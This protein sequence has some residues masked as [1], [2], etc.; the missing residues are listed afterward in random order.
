[1]VKYFALI[2]VLFVGRSGSIHSQE[3]N[4]DEPIL[5]GIA[6]PE[7]SEPSTQPILTREMLQNMSKKPPKFIPGLDHPPS[8]NPLVPF[9]PQPRPVVT[10]TLSDRG[11]LYVIGL[12]IMLVIGFVKYQ[13]RPTNP[14]EVTIGDAVTRRRQWIILLVLAAVIGGAIF[15]F[16]D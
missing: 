6:K 3:Q 2:L 1:M 15:A 16:G 7:K 8:T 4:Q 9:D 5:P 11:W 14:A 12:T 10:R 13:F